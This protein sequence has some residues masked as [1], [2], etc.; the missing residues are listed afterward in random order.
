ME[1]GRPVERLLQSPRG[2][3]M[4][5]RTR[6]GS[7]GV[8]REQEVSGWILK[9][10]PTE[11]GLNVGYARKIGFWPEQLERWSCQLLIVAADNQTNFQG[12]V[13]VD[14]VPAKPIYLPQCRPHCRSCLT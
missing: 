12:M 4:L 13:K 1:I 2:E 9:G 14:Q 11:L 3:M 6:V 10:E 5:A 8:V 7:V